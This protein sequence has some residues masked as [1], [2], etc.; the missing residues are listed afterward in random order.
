MIRNNGD[1]SGYDFAALPPFFFFFFLLSGDD[2]NDGQ[3]Q[4]T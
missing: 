2:G 1:D 4:G 3:K